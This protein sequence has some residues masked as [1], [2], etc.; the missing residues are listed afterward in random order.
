MSI[1]FAAYEGEPL[2]PSLTRWVHRRFAIDGHKL[3]S[4]DDEQ[5]EFVATFLLPA[6]DREE[7]FSLR[8]FAIHAKNGMGP[9]MRE[10]V[11]A[12]LNKLLDEVPVADD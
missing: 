8:N 5:A 7:Y 6:I 4:L 2:L 11:A 1:D 9:C 10:D 12:T 3:K